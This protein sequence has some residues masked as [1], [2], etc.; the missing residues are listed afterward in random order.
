MISFFVGTVALLVV[1]LVLHESLPWLGVVSNAPWWVWT[2][3]FLG[4]FYVLAT[5][6][7]IPG[8][9]PRLQ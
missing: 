8:S 6:V 4:A 3:G 1:A 9:A 2:G 7:L 5:I